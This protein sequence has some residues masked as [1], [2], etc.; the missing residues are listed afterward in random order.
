MRDRLRRA[1]R[2]RGDAQSAHVA[3][4]DTA[5]V[6]RVDAHQARTKGRRALRRGNSRSRCRLGRR[7]RMSRDGDDAAS[8]RGR[9]G[10]GL[11]RC[12]LGARAGATSTAPATSST[13]SDCG[14]SDGRGDPATGEES[15]GPRDGAPR[16]GATDRRVAEE[17]TLDLAGVAVVD[18]RGATAGSSAARSR[19]SCSTTSARRRRGRAG[20]AP[21]RD[22]GASRAP[23]LAAP[24]AHGSA[25][26]EDVGLG[27]RLE[28][29]RPPVRGGLSGLR[30]SSL[31]SLFGLGQGSSVRH[32]S[33]FSARGA[34]W[35]ILM[36]TS[37]SPSSR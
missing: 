4:I 23:S 18:R 21:D 32:A 26:S 3:D 27:A 6:R 5:L 36:S 13:P 33:T 35:T 25:A 29:E 30:A 15:S 11:G 14:H 2:A 31:R 20:G 22:R 37:D 16:H 9:V 19:R 28:R 34:P 7:S 17:G 12:C 1:G 8:G 24:R 10:E